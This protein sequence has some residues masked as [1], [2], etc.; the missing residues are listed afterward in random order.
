[1][2]TLRPLGPRVVWTAS[3]SLSQPISILALASKPKLSCL[4]EKKQGKLRVRPLEFDLRYAET[5]DLANIL[6][7]VSLWG[8][9]FICLSILIFY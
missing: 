3:A 7:K 2:T 5:A 9:I 1:M 6:S 8:S 4:A